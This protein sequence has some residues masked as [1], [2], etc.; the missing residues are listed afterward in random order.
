MRG[1]TSKRLLALAVAITGRPRHHGHTRRQARAMR[2]RWNT[3][4]WN[5]RSLAALDH[6]IAKAKER[7]AAA[8]SARSS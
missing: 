7:R 6:E 4:P 3:L 2:R 1:T 8:V 5:R